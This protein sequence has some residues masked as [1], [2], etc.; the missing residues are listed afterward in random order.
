VGP[1]HDAAK[2]DALAA[3]E[4]FVLPTLGENYAL[5]VAEALSAGVP[6]LTTRAARPWQVLEARGCGWWVAPGVEGLTEALAHATALPAATLAAMGE[7]GIAVAREQCQWSDAAARSLAIYRWLLDTG[8]RP[9][10][11]VTD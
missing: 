5:V 6:V 7:R 10:Y 9:A 8:E 2:R 11:V 4:L 3:A 1:L